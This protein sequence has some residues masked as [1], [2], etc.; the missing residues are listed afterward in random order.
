VIILLAAAM[1]LLS[2]TAAGAPFAASS[3]A[4]TAPNTAEQSLPPQEVEVTGERPGPRL[5][6]VSKADHVIWLL[7]TLDP[8]PRRML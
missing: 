7:G 3:A 8:L 5:W 4:A 6:R 2:G 1:A